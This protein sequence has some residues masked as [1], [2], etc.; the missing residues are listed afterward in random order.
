[1]RTYRA[2]DIKE[3]DWF[4]VANRDFIHITKC[5]RTS[6]RL[7][8]EGMYEAEAWRFHRGSADSN[9]SYE[10]E[11]SPRLYTVAMIEKVSMIRSSHGEFAECMI[12][13]LLVEPEER[14]RS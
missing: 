8:I 5:V 14:Q 1:M 7:G 11:E 12:D 4:E 10:K 13:Y 9:P 2:V 3:G 6:E